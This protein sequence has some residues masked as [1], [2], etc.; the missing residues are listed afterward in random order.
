M[1]T[2]KLAIITMGLTVSLAHAACEDITGAKLQ[3]VKVTPDDHCYFAAKNAPVDPQTNKVIDGQLTVDDCRN[4]TPPDPQ[5]Y[6]VSFIDNN[7]ALGFSN[8]CE[9]ARKQH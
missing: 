1:N 3:L 7:A 4:I 9:I 8:M 6:G 2:L 5:F